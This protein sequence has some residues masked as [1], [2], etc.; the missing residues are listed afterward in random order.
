MIV[1]V[2]LA[3]GLL[4]GKMSAGTTFA[5]DDHRAF[6]REGESFDKGETFAG[7]P[8][9]LALEAVE[10][11]R[12]LVPGGATMAQFAL[13]WILMEH[14]VS[15]VIPGA[16]NAAQAIANSQASTLDAI[17]PAAMEQLRA[18]YRERIAPHVHHLW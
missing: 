4:T 10:Q 3:S 16:R 8:Y 2:P 5:A 14:G 11:I 6:N 13:R 7:V 9:D 17:S 15:T 18:L 12:A 1:R